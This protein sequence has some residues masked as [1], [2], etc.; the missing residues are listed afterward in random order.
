MMLGG[1]GLKVELVCFF[2]HAS[3]GFIAYRDRK[4]RYLSGTFWSQDGSIA[5]I[6]LNKIQYLTW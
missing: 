2:L 1:G 4:E 6:Q 3:H 5:L